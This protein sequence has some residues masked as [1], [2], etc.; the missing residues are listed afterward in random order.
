MEG[1]IQKR[2][3]QLEVRSFGTDVVKENRISS[4]LIREMNYWGLEIKQSS[5]TPLSSDLEFVS[6]SDVVISADQKIF[7]ELSEKGIVS[8][9]ICNFAVDDWHIPYDP[10]DF[11]SDKYFANAAKVIHCTARLV[12]EF[13]DE[14]NRENS[15]W[16]YS[17]P[18]E[19][20]PEH[21]R[22]DATVIDARLRKSV[23]Q[24]LPS[25]EI[26]FFEERELLDGSLKSSLNNE[27]TVY[28][29]KFEFR[30]P[31]K[32]LLSRDWSDFVRAVS[33]FRP[34]NVITAPLASNGKSL[35]EPYLASLVAD[36]VEYG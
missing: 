21:F 12:S 13:F 35:T 8:T 22:P 32:I 30:E 17:T 36:Y 7:E 25:G 23:H 31:E 19:S 3:P 9:N 24:T 16:A 18:E 5:P 26:R 20:I 1:Y 28:S 33:R 27:T 2:F 15:I 4:Q 11:S 10:I 29:P 6:A 14:R 34:V